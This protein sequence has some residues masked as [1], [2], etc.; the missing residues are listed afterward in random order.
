MAQTWAQ[1]ASVGADHPEKISRSDGSDCVATNGEWPI[2][3]GIEACDGVDCGIYL[4]VL[5]LIEV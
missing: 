5:V 2:S 3:Q 4:P 1:L